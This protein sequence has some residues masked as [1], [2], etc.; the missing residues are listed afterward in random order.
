[1]KGKKVTVLELETGRT[2]ETIAQAHKEMNIS[3]SLLTSARAIV[4]D[5]Q[6]VRVK[7]RM[8]QFESSAVSCKTKKGTAIVCHETGVKYP[9]MTDAAKDMGV[10]T[11]AISLAVK[12]QGT[13]RGYHWSK[14]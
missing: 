10:K 1:M 14:I 7:G 6:P 2:H 5:N 3:M 9:S 12:K 13:C 8:L 11:A 4:G